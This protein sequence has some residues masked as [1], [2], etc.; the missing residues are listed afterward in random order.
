MATIVLDATDRREL[1]ERLLRY[2]QVDT[3]SDEN[4][5]TSPSTEKQKVLARML[6]QEL[7]DLGCPDA[8][9][10]QWGYVYATVPGNLPKGHK[11][12]GKVPTIGLIAH[13]DTYQGT[14]GA[15][16]KPQVIESY[17]GG[18]RSE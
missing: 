13:V 17:A 4:S 12:K 8:V 11:A 5:T 6:A 18:D 1:L 10:D 16:V 3:Q 2:A 9:M 14:L 7:K 15:G